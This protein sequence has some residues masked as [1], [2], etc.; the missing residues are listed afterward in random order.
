[1]QR[2]PERGGI[3]GGILIFLGILLLCGVALVLS[4]GYLVVHN[5]HVSRSAAKGDTRVETPFGTLRVKERSRLD[6]RAF[7]VPVYPGARRSDDAHRLASF[8][9][10]F[11]DTHKD[12]AVAAAEYVTSDPLARVEEYYRG[13]LPDA[14][15]KH[16]RHHHIVFEFNEGGMKKV[17]ALR[18][19]GSDTR[20]ALASIG[21]PAAN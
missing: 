14:A 7:G 21:E 20:I 2:N 12:L 13:K 1:M 4:T 11:G 8:E 19:Q 3:L 9:L 6:A 18:E 15:V 5:I 10:D 17:V 16:G